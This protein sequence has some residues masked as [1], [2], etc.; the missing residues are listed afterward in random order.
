MAAIPLN[1]IDRISVQIGTFAT[2]QAGI[3]TTHWKVFG[4]V[5]EVTLDEVVDSFDEALSDLYKPLMA[6]TAS[7]YGI[8]GQRYSPGEKT[9]A[10]V[11]AENIGPGTAGASLLP[12]QTCGIV[13]TYSQLAGSGNRGRLFVPFPSEADNDDGTGLPT[14]GYKARLQNLA[15]FLGATQQFLYGARSITLKPVIRHSGSV[16]DIE[17]SGAIGKQ[18]WGT[19]RRR[20]SYGQANTYPPF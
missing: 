5:G 16:T 4:M 2:N 11:S 6:N 13:S 20:G 8:R 7:F 10:V 1:V 12:T 17:I 9:V 14:A 15:D 3:N 19:Q 18:K